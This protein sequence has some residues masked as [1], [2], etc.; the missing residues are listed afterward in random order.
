MTEY[1]ELK[2]AK[3]AIHRIME[4]WPNLED[5]ICDYIDAV[6]STDVVE[7]TRGEWFD[8]GSMSCRCSNCGCK[9]NKEYSFC[10]NCGADMRGKK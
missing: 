10:P 2:T 1:I 3:E 8:V 4:P 9:A 7:R 5:D 6:P